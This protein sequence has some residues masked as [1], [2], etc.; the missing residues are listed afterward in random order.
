MG[1]VVARLE[2]VSDRVSPI[3]VKEIRQFVRSRE[4]L[5]SFATSLIIA[6][7]IAFFGSTQAVT[8]SRTAGATTF[9][10]LTTCLAL[11]GL[12]VVPLGAFTTLRTERLEQ[13]LDLISLTTMS[14]RRIVVGK[15]GAQG[16]KLMTF[17][18]IMTPFVAT[19]FLLG[20]IDF[21][22]I[23]TAM[24]TVFL[25]SMWVASAALF[26][27]TMF[28][29][30]LMSGLALGLVGIGVFIVYTA[31][32]SLL[33]A[34][35]F[36][37]IAP[38]SPLGTSTMPWWR[39]GTLVVFGL[40][41]M[42]NLVLLAESRLTL[43][44]ENR[45]SALRVGL[46]AQFL[47]IVAHALVSR[48]GPG[49]VASSTLQA[50]TFVG[51]L[52]LALVAAFAVTEG[53][54]ASNPRVAMPPWL[55]RWP[56]LSAVFGPGAGRAALYV[57]LQ[58]WVF[59]GTGGALGASNS[60]MKL[61][62]A[63]CGTICL[64]TGLPA[65]VVH[66]LSSRGLGT[67][68]ARGFMLLLL[69]FSLVLPDLVYYVFWRPEYLSLQFGARHLFSPVLPLLDWDSVHAK[70]W[71]AIPLT[72]SALGVATYL[73]MIAVAKASEERVQAVSAVP[74]YEAVNGSRDDDHSR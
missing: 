63:L 1:Y 59:M 33:L 5:A 19:S 49:Y 4:F 37:G 13:T 58:M 73:Y 57:L 11:L 35:R 40:M 43:P 67:L 38:F 71:Q 24:A 29:S 45:V 14:P 21:V 50:F 69:M 20:G 70:G 60:E 28:Q 15:L 66:R 34:F 3:V 52:H 44:T 23:L 46:L 7:L 16:V 30:R 18:A 72:W 32:R 41:T 26:V 74:V 53:T 42:T 8:G 36:G 12:A 39:F 31:G 22:T 47:L 10:T 25:A 27:S 61:L 17:F 68:H 2:A 55:R 48:F 54:G 64:L 9:T 51:A 65:L 62:A 6:L 56:F